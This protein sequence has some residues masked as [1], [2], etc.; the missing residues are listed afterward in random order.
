MYE[1][2]KK[3][4][5]FKWVYEL[6]NFQIRTH[7][8]QHMFT[9]TT[10]NPKTRPRYLSLSLL[11]TVVVPS[12]PVGVLGIHAPVQFF[13]A[14]SLSCIEQLNDK[15]V[16]SLFGESHF[17]NPQ[18]LLISLSSLIRST[19]VGC[20]RRRECSPPDPRNPRHPTHTHHAPLRPA[21]LL[22][23]T[24]SAVECCAV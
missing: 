22:C 11:C 24:E 7:L 3:I 1:Y 12:K 4:S 17:A 2:L 21:L 20:N 9:N 14:M 23:C 19:C 5:T 13:V 16:L 6:C 10:K 15:R 18:R 8:Q